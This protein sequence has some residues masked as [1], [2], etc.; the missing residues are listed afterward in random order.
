MDRDDELSG[1]GIRPLQERNICRADVDEQNIEKIY[2]LIISS[3]FELRGYFYCR[4]T[5]AEVPAA[6]GTGLHVHRKN[7]QKTQKQQ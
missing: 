4:N 5:C 2:G 3:E 7:I 1:G 6:I